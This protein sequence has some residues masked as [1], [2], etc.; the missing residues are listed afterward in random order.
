MEDGPA[1]AGHKRRR[2][3]AAPSERVGRAGLAAA[4]SSAASGS[5]SSSSKSAHIHERSGRSDPVSSASSGVKKSSGGGFQ[6]L[7]LSPPVF[8]GV[9]RMGFKVPTPIQRR[10]LPVA[11]SGRDVVAMARTGSG[12]TAA[13]VI[14]MLERLRGHSSKSV[15]GVIL[16]PTRELAQQTHKVA[17]SMGK[18]TD[19]RII[20]LVGGESMNEQFAALASHPDV[21]IATPGR[22]MHLLME[23]PGFTLK[24][25]EYVVFDEADRL[26]EMGFAEQLGE[27]LARMPPHRQ[28]L[29]FSAT[30]P[31][32]LVAFARA[33]LKE[34]ALM[35]LDVDTKVSENLRLAL[36]TVRKEEK[37]AAL[38]WLVRAV[39]PEDQQAIVFVSTR[40]HTEFLSLLLREG[41]VS[42]EAVY[43]D[44]DMTQ[45]VSNLTRFRN[46]KL[47]V[48]VCTDVAARGLDLPLLD[49]VINYDFPDKSK[50]F[51][52]RCG[53]VARQGRVGTAFSLVAA[54]DMPYM[55]DT[56][57]FLGRPVTNGAQ[58]STAV[59]TDD[60]AE[61]DLSAPLPAGGATGGDDADDGDEDDASDDD[62][63]GGRGDDFLADRAADAS[64]VHDPDDAASVF[65]SFAAA[66]TRGSSASTPSA[67]YTLETMTPADVHYGQ[68]PRSAME[69]DIERVR[70]L[71]A[72]NRD[73]AAL[74][75]SCANAM[76]LYNRSRAP[77]SRSSLARAKALPHDAVHPLL[78]EFEVE[79]EESMRSYLAGLSSF[80][81]AQTVF[82]TEATTHKDK[83][84]KSKSQ[85]V[86]AAK[87]NAH[88][89]AIGARVG[90]VSVDAAAAAAARGALNMNDFGDTL[91]AGL[92]AAA[93]T[94]RANVTHNVLAAM[95]GG[96]A[97]AAAHEDAAAGDEDTEPME[98]V[99]EVGGDVVSS[100]L[101]P[102]DSASARAKP[103]MSAKARRAMRSGGDTAA[104]TDDAMSEDVDGA[105]VV[106]HSSGTG[107]GAS[108]AR[109]KAALARV[110]SGEDATLA[111]RDMSQYVAFGSS[112]DAVTEAGLSAGGVV[113][114][115]EGSGPARGDTLA[116]DI[117]DAAQFADSTMELM[118]DEKGNLHAHNRRTRYWDKQKKKYVLAPTSEFKNGRRIMQLARRNESGAKVNVDGKHKYGELYRKWVKSTRK[119]VE[120]GDD[121]DDDGGGGGTSNSKYASSGGKKVVSFGGGDDDGD[122]DAAAAGGAPHRKR[123]RHGA[124][125]AP[126]GG[127]PG[128]AGK[129]VREELRSVGQI[130]KERLR[131]AKSQG[132]LRKFTSTGR[133]GGS[134]GGRAGGRGGSRGGGR[135]GGRGGSRKGAA[136]TRSHTLRH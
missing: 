57:L 55:L 78:R 117:A 23:V 59:V 83:G 105:V 97:G 35:R 2:S 108:R 79:N 86:M 30:L 130:K 53:R 22:L 41:G 67:A 45:R 101:A 98:D 13:F 88:A 72:S 121:D 118:P 107:A 37:A 36:F 112:A 3:E 135:G 19:L 127:A 134:A 17:R 77:A 109:T 94:G 120:G 80:R 39:I 50:L 44:M 49:N 6:S 103:R 124:S 82:E 16:S 26:F 51:V 100:L 90:S 52:H 62:G 24:G 129:H 60:A 114:S 66:H 73:C 47:R 27:I 122:A 5:H 104:V 110:L 70:H 9:M 40:H 38:V 43:G 123:A 48:L 75:K 68:I 29:L 106:E 12:K 31:S 18:F 11:L 84:N 32:A 93:R 132:K 125:P 113:A 25:V 87:R 14:P 8:A 4:S 76:Q 65:S 15:R 64:S 34:P 56:L 92:D 1:H 33:G 61:D 89:H 91:R 85:H 74:A 42:A 63:A 115:A 58:H 10:S 46:R 71:V 131:K 28:T 133:G 111:F 81:P 69:L 126:S 54:S 99:D 116:N 136:P 128:S 20:S 102:P 7:G 119:Q 95:R 21:V 96:R